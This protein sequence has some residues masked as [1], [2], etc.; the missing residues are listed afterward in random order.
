LS[1]IDNKIA[2]IKSRIDAARMA[3][4][5]AEA[6]KETAK[7]SEQQAMARLQEEFGVDNLSVARDK[8]AELQGQLQTCV[9][10]ITAQLDEVEFSQR[11]QF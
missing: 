5:R 11:I 4:A 10:E 2:M 8:L 9:D 1:D 6:T 3:K 7:A